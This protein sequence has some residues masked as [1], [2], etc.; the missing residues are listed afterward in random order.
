MTAQF[1]FIIYICAAEL[2]SMAGTMYFPALLPGFRAEWNLTNT[3]AGWINGIFYGGYAAFAPILVSL[4]DRFDPRRI[5]LF[6]AAVGAASMIGFGWL[7]EGT[8]SASAFRLLAGISLAGTYMPGVKVLSDHITG[9]G[10][11]RSVA[12]YTATY[13]LGTALS[14][15]LS[16]WI[17]TWLH[18]RWTALLLSAGPLMAVIIFALSVEARKPQRPDM[19]PIWS[20]FDF[21]LALRNR[22][23]L[24][25]TLGYAVHCWELFGFRTWVVAFLFFSLSLQP[26][27]HYLSPQNLAT[28]VV[29]AGVPASVLGNEGAV[30][31]GRRLIVS[32]Y[33]VASGLLGCVIGFCAGW[34]F[35]VVMG[36]CLLYGIAMMLDSGSLTAGVVAAA[37]D[38]ERGITLAVYSFMGFGMAFLSPLAVGGIL[39]ITGGGTYGWGLA[40]AALGIVSMSGPLWLRL[41]RNREAALYP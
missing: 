39:D 18:W 5:Y 29:L 19:R 10:Q 37:H 34:P 1:K 14:V 2:F 9:K 4:T 21:R 33:M 26:G 11:S 36:L 20:Y 40:L 7:A 15:F 23:A 41:F 38:G 3:E 6:S 30:R 35:G 13:G 28:L 27:S 24:G 22:L 31:W 8:L 25:Y 17:T 12:F 32:L 16:G